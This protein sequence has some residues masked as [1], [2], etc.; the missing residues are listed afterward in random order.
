MTSYR[1]HSDEDIAALY[2]DAD[3]DT[4][5][6]LRSEMARRDAKDAT[7]ARD[8]AR[9]AAVT[10]AWMDWQHA[11][12]LAADAECRGNLLSR[13]GAAAGISEFS[14]WTGSAEDAAR[15]AS[16]ELR[17]FWLSHPRLSVSQFRAQARRGR[18][19]A[20]EAAGK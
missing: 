9:W 20:R 5:A 4:A 19:A 8:A 3:E 15:Y 6:E 13:E 11:Q 16:E 12:Y 17:E 2:A 10:Q 7:H 14:L 1:N 18:K